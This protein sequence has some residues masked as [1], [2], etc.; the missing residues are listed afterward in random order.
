MGT[1]RTGR[2]IHPDIPRG[3]DLAAEPRGVTAV[4]S[5]GGVDSAVNYDQGELHAF[6]MT[7]GGPREHAPVSI[8]RLRKRRRS[9]PDDGGSDRQGD[10]TDTMVDH[11]TP[12]VLPRGVCFVGPEPLM[13]WRDRHGSA[14]GKD[15]PA[16]IELVVHPRPED[17]VADARVECRCQRRARYDNRVGRD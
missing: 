17:V 11:G 12:L 5:S 4:G 16:P 6:A 7:P 14:L 9:G 3:G 15:R 2:Y 10:C 1:A 13:S 8:E